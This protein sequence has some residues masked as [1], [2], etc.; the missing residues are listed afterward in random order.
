VARLAVLASGNGSNFEA[1]V[2]AL[3]ARPESEGPRH[4]CQLLAY[5]R[6]DAVAAQ[7][8]ARLGVPSRNV[9]FTGRARFEA[10][11]EITA[12]LE[13]A[14]ADLVALAGF[15]RVLS[16]GFVRRWTGRVLNIHPSLL[17]K[18]PGAHAIKD[19]YESGERD[20]GVTVH[21]IDEGVDTGPIVA[22]E[23]F[24]AEEGE[25]MDSIEERTH[26]IEHRLYARVALEVLDD[27]ERARRPR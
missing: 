14:D 11:A 15:M 13:E 19:A 7:R 18:W 16:P 26:A 4:E 6:K 22:Q 3:R 8:A 2:A 1:L 12:A 5:D 21:Y 25:P 27:I 23:S 9:N 20:F 10:E 17:P 24:R